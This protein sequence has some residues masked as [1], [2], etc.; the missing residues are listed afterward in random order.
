MKARGERGV[1][2][3]VLLLLSYN[4][5]IYQNDARHYSKRRARRR[6]G[7]GGAPAVIIAA[8]ATENRRRRGFV[9]HRCRAPVASRRRADDDREPALLFARH[10]FKRNHRIVRMF[11]A[12]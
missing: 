9:V 4:R 2:A 7:A 3:Y 5:E 6:A 10:C 11:A 1:G 8:T 12:I